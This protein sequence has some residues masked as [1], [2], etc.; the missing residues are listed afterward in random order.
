MINRMRS[1]VAVSRSVSVLA[2]APLGQPAP[3][4]AYLDLASLQMDTI[5]VGGFCFL[6]PICDF[7]I[8]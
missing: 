4:P 5:K 8:S 7:S 6:K 3:A 1:P 2:V